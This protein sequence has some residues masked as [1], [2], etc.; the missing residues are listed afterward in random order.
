[1]GLALLQQIGKTENITSSPRVFCSYRFFARV[2]K[3]GRPPVGPTRG[4]VVPLRPTRGPLP[5]CRL[6][7]AQAANRQQTDSDLKRVDQNESAALGA[8]PM[9]GSRCPSLRLACWRPPQGANG[10]ILAKPMV[11]RSSRHDCAPGK[12]CAPPRANRIASSPP[13]DPCFDLPRSPPGLLFV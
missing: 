8:W 2:N 1:M 13:Q 9:G 6:S 11:A 12:H 7:D 5:R 3:R 4:A 10:P